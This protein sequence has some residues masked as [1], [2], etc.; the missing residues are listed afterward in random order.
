MTGKVP[1]DDAK[2]QV[3]IVMRVIEGNLPLLREQAELAQ[4]IALCSLVADCWKFSPEDRPN[5]S[6]CLDEIS[7]MVSLSSSH[8]T[9]VSS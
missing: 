8:H 3:A 6:K 9:G 2:E 5:A 7:W 1:F 4:I